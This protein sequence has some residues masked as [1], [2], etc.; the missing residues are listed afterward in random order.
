MTK[1]IKSF[2]PLIIPF[3]LIFIG[4]ENEI[5]QNYHALKA[6][7]KSRNILELVNKFNAS[8]FNEI[9]NDEQL[10]RLAGGVVVIDTITEGIVEIG[11]KKFLKS[12][13]VSKPDFIKES[14][15]YLLISS[16]E[17]ISH[18]LKEFSNNELQIAVELDTI[19]KGCDRMVISLD[20]Q[21]L[22]SAGEVHYTKLEGKVLDILETESDYYFKHLHNQREFL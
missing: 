19:T 8:V 18:K 9:N 11:K 13:L 4:C 20:G 3:L 2:I 1:T 14:E 7:K 12:K 21:M 10:F 5:E 6:E 17:N 16:D 15:V 22:S